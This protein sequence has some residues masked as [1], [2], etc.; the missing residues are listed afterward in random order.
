MYPL[1][2]RVLL[3]GVVVLAIATAFVGV[4]RVAAHD[5]RPREKSR[6]QDTRRPT[7]LA[8]HAHATGAD[9]PGSTTTIIVVPKPR[10]TFPRPISDLPVRVTTGHGLDGR[11]LRL[12]SGGHGRLGPG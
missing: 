4:A 9:S 1:A 7:P 6:V 2:S 12:T 10:A 8:T 5:P 3:A 11:V